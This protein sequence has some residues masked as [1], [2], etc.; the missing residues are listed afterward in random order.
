MMYVT[1]TPTCYRNGRQVLPVPD[2]STDITAHVL[3]ESCAAATADVGSRLVSQQ[4]A[5]RSLGVSAQRPAYAEDPQA[6][7]AALQQVGEAAEL[8]D[9]DGLG[10][11]TWLLQARG[12]PLPVDV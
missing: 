9:P 10:G 1:C 5:L 2:G 6:Y 7:L 12:V 11:L 8:L 3:M 4:D